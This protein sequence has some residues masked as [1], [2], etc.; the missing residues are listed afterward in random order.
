MKVTGLLGLLFASALISGCSVTQNSS[1]KDMASLKSDQSYSY[2]LRE[3][4]C[5]ERAMFF[6]ANRSSR[7]GLVAVGTVVMN[8]VNSSQYPDT[9]CRV[10]G[11]KNQ[12]A[13]GVLTRLMNRK[14]LPDVQAAAEAVLKGERHPK[15]K[16]AMFFHTA[17][18]K[19]PYNNM[20]YVLVAGGNAFYEKRSRDGTLSVPVDDK[21]YDVS[22][23]FAQE[24]TG[25]LPTAD[26]MKD[27][28]A[29]P[30]LDSKTTMAAVHMPLVVPV[31]K[32]RAMESAN[33]VLGYALPEARQINLIGALL[34][35][36]Q[37]K[38]P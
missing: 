17:G 13:P 9:I 26:M 33:L 36:Q 37:Y 34:L 38:N 4:A 7:E 28:A 6:E 20:H 30:V 12:F 1:D 25:A 19:F 35:A 22:Y 27:I 3:R 10:V 21:P 8:R 15:L 16:N 24:N 11:Q 23:A 32:P 14:V 5:L 2:P 31:P 18:L 29:K